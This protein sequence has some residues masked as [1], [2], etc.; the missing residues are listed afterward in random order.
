MLDNAAAFTGTPADSPAPVARTSDLAPGGE[1]SSAF[2][3]VV[4]GTSVLV[5]PGV[6]AGVV[7]G[8]M[9]AGTAAA[10]LDGTGLLERGDGAATGAGA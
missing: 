9:A 7:A 6:I 3:T 4:V 5:F 8:I 2:S 1:G 10:G